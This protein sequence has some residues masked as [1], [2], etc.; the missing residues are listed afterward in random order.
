[1]PIR[2]TT[3]ASACYMPWKAMLLGSLILT[4]VVNV[5]LWIA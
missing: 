4:V 3:G 1:M 5:V 2:R